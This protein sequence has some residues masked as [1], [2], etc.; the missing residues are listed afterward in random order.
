MGFAGKREG[1]ED[2]KWGNSANERFSLRLELEVRE[3]MASSAIYKAQC[4]GE[5][6]YM[7][8]C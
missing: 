1:N 4:V 7:L 5:C 6:V 8:V 3:S 2:G